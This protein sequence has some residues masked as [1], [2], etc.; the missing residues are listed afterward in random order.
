MLLVKVLVSL[1]WMSQHLIFLVFSFSGLLSVSGVLLSLGLG[2]GMLLMGPREQCNYLGISP[3]WVLNYYNARIFADWFSAGW[4][5]FWESFVD[6]SWHKHCKLIALSNFIDIFFLDA[7]FWSLR[8][9]CSLQ[10]N[11]RMPNKWM[12][13]PNSAVGAGPGS[14]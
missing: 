5:F 12:T 4:P 6:C 11:Y 1:G 10:D 3:L 7:H 2:L 14:F 13:K 9:S 8:N